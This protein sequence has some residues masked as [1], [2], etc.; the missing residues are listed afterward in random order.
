MRIQ[1]GAMFILE[2]IQ[3][4]FI[5]LCIALNLE[6]GLQFGKTQILVECIL[7]E[8]QSRQWNPFKT[9]SDLAH[10]HTITVASHYHHGVPSHRQL[11]PFVHKL[12]QAN[13]KENIKAL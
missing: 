4:M 13:D 2:L 11:D 12:V 1:W 6:T 9:S 3:N 7:N 8:V 10:T 5:R